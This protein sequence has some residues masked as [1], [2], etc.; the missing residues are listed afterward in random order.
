MYLNGIA[1]PP[2]TCTSSRVAESRE[3]V[4]L[5]AEHTMVELDAGT[6]GAEN[7]EVTPKAE[8]LHWTLTDAMKPEPEMVIKEPPATGEVLSDTEAHDA[9]KLSCSWVEIV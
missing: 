6:T 7:E 4:H 3:L 8:N 2:K 9:K 5:G 1:C